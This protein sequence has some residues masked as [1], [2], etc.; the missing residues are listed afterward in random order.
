[1]SRKRTFSLSKSALIQFSQ[2][3]R[4]YFESGHKIETSLFFLFFLKAPF[5]LRL[6]K[7]LYLFGL[8]DTEDKG[9]DADISPENK[10][11][12][13]TEDQSIDEYESF[14][15]RAEDIIAAKDAHNLR[16]LEAKEKKAAAFTAQDE[17]IF[18]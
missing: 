14:Q 18:F 15:Q 13:S 4:N 16:A 2:Y 5:F 10:V 7:C 3:F 9:F 1:M 11:D 12:D 8:L 17:V 6:F